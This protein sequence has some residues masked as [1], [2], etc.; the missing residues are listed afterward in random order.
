MAT[1]LGIAIGVVLALLGGRFLES[2]LFDTS[3]RH[4]AAFVGVALALL[5]VSVVAGFIPARRAMRVDP[6]TALR[7]E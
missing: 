3:P 6:M 4:P 2:L 7:A 1:A 5:I